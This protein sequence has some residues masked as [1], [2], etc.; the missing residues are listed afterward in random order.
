MDDRRQKNQLELAFMEEGIKAQKPLTPPLA[1]ARM[2]DRAQSRA[3]PHVFN[4]S[5][6]S[7]GLIRTGMLR[8]DESP[9]AKAIR[10]DERDLGDDRLAHGGEKPLEG[11]DGPLL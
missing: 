9:I 5:K 7:N 10:T 8:N 2:C 6:R 1:A 3:T 11:L 4:V